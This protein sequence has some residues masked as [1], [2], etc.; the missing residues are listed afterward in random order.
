M[1]RCNNL[2][3]DQLVLGI[4]GGGS[5]TLAWLAAR[6]ASAPLEPI[7]QGKAGASN[8]R[9]VGT[10]AA[11]KQ[12]MQAVGAAFADAG[13]RRQPVAAAGI[14]LAGVGNE[15]LRREILAWC[16]Q[17]PL[18]ARIE[19]V[20]DALAVLYAGD[21]QGLGIALIAGTGSFAFGRAAPDREARAGGWGYLFGDEGSGYWL[22][23]EALRAITHAADGRQPISLL[24]E[25]ILRDLNLAEPA[26]LIPTFCQAAPDRR[27]IAN[28]APTV[29]ACAERNDPAARSIVRRAA[30]QL[31]EQVG[32][33][34]RRLEIQTTSY[35][36]CLAVGL[37]THSPLLVAAVTD[38]LEQHQIAPRA[39]QGVQ[40]PVAGA[41]RIARQAS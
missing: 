11:G 6:D 4:D 15:S 39:V 31:A 19:V 35:L 5:K 9:V 37:L 16:Q 18:A 13:L 8:P 23:I 27:A 17:Q 32:A 10:E 34:A 26:A 22:G 20:H 28:L 21:T 24:T 41:V 36:L 14:A 3:A 7:G 38:Y 25:R 33:V 2:R 29:L 12:I 30:Q 40:H 1:T